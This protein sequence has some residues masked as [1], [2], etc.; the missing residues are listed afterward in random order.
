[1]RK[2]ISALVVNLMAAQAFA[3]ACAVDSGV[4]IE[5]LEEAAFHLPED[6]PIKVKGEA[7]L[8]LSACGFECVLGIEN[9]Q[10]SY[11]YELMLSAKE[12]VLDFGDAGIIRF[13]T[14]YEIEV[15]IAD[16]AFD[17]NGASAVFRELRI[18]ILGQGTGSFGKALERYHSARLILSGKG[19]ACPD[20]SAYS[21]WRFD[22]IGEIA[23]Y[24]IYGE[25][26]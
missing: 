13:E 4:R 23:D 14:P 10:E 15:L 18:D 7:Y 8:Y 25:M 24:A 21:H 22:V 2:I 6:E 1:M 5:N 26:K 3:S 11:P 12:G 16:R 19:G 20:I 9:P 17:P